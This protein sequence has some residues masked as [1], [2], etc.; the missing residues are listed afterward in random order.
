MRTKRRLVLVFFC[1]H[2]LFCNNNKVYAAEG[3]NAALEKQPVI[4]I[5][6][7]GS[8]QEVSGGAANLQTQQQP[9]DMPEKP[10]SEKASLGYK[11]GKIIPWILFAYAA[12]YLLRKIKKR[13]KQEQ[14][15]KEI[16]V[17]PKPKP[18]REPETISEAV[19]S[20]VKHRLRK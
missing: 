16:K 4:N 11:I 18:P 15:V 3:I 20:F 10:I 2:F 6:T 14:A 5:Q 19:V 12:I 8:S 7:K 13:K 9:A 1:L 17:P